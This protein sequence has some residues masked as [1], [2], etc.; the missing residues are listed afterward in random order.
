M[1]DDEMKKKVI[2]VCVEVK[3][4]YEKVMVLDQD[5]LRLVIDYM[6]DT[7]NFDL[8]LLKKILGVKGDVTK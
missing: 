4:L 3:H 5:G 2:E 1:M 7:Q 6:D 8:I